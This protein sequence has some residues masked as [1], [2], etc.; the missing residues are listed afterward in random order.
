MPLFFQRVDQRRRER[1]MLGIEVK[2]FSS[3][4]LV[5]FGF[6]L[7]CGSREWGEITVIGAL[8]TKAVSVPKRRIEMNAFL[9]PIPPLDECYSCAL[10]ACRKCRL[11]DPSRARS[12]CWS[13][14]IPCGFKFHGSNE[15]VEDGVSLPSQW[16][17]SRSAD[18]FYDLAHDIH[19]LTVQ[20]GTEI[21]SGE[22]DE[23]DAG[24]V[25]SPADVRGDE[26]IPGS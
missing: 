8:K 17:S 7:H 6:W 2:F 11:L 3:R 15:T 9:N 16:G 26:K 14:P 21:G 25:A 18:Y 20:E 23:S 1:P 24:F 13:M 22:V 19:R 12:R 4:C 10:T 5:Y